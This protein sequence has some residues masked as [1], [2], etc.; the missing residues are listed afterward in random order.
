MH[1]EGNGRVRSRVSPSLCLCLCW[2]VVPSRF[3]S[4]P[5]FDDPCL[6][7]P[8]M[9]TSLIKGISSMGA[10]STASVPHAPDIVMGNP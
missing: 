3:F 9:W 2:Q 4:R 8:S 6:T 5:Y 7:K 10:L 1:N